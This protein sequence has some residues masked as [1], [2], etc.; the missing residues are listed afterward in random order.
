MRGIY[1]NKMLNIKPIEVDVTQ[2]K[3]INMNAKGEF[4]PPELNITDAKRTEYLMKKHKKLKNLTDPKKGQLFQGHDMFDDFD[5]FDNVYKNQVLS[6]FR[7]FADNQTKFIKNDLVDCVSRMYRL[8]DTINAI[9]PG[10]MNQMNL[11][12]SEPPKQRSYLFRKL[13]PTGPS[14]KEH[15]FE[16]DE[17]KFGN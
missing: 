1:R 6:R 14:S 3:G 2:L 4:V 7:F 15:P 17:T 9:V 11:D 13:R 8:D 10:K 12:F 16:F 5:E